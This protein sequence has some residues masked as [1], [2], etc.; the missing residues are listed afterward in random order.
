MNR[1]KQKFRRLAG[2]TALL[3]SFLLA[4]PAWAAPAYVLLKLP[5]GARAQGNLMERLSAWRLSG[6]VSDVLVLDKAESEGASVDKF[7]TLEFP[8]EGY[9]DAWMKEGRPQIQ[10]PIEVVRADVLTHGEKTPRDSNLSLFKV[11][12]YQPTISPA[13]S[14]KYAEGYIKPQMEGQLKARY[15]MRYTMY[16]ERVPNGKTW[17]LME[18]RDRHNY[19]RAEPFKERELRPQLLAQNATYAQFDKTKESLRKAGGETIATYTELP[20]P[21][22]AH[23]PSYKPESKVVGGLRIVGSELKNAVNQLAEG[24][25]SFHPEAKLS[26][27]HIPSSEGGIAGL[28]LGVS[29]VAP[30]GD[31]AKITDIMPFY[32]TFGYLP[33]EVSVATG[34][35]EKRG[36]LFAW[37]ITTHK[38]NPIDSITLD[39]LARTIGSERTGGWEVIN[40][41]YKY[42]AKYALTKDQL[43]RNWSQLGVRSGPCRG[44]EIQTYGYTAPGFAIAIERHLMHWSNKYNPNF[45]EYVEAK[46]ASPG[47]EGEIASTAALEELSRNPCGLAIM[48]LM[49]V[50]NYPNLKVLKVAPRGGGAP[51]ALTP[52]NVANRTYPLIRDAYFYLNRA[53]G[54]PLDPKVREFMRF[55]LSR[56]GQEIISR[57][58]YY[59]PLTAQEL[60]RQLAKLN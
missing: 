2:L 21:D 32:N 14:K 27:S 20:P 40:N 46:Q 23:L 13:E 26:T 60:Q 11:N 55:V 43:I 25:F 4:G 22:L 54:Q 59:Y 24:F 5:V 36:S 10:A 37:A 48:P 41:D 3:F 6:Q 39:Q 38:D 15:L 31:D 19:Q 42:S 56:E 18:Y 34:G 8:S 33:T 12:D 17:L 1:V 58:G 53:P 50:K 44:K 57:V 52:E 45:K 9:Y 49:H 29:D 47:S 7:I 51:V 28:Y 30:M 16:L 35:Y